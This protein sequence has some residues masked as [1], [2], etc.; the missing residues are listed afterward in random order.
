[1]PD[2]ECEGELGLG[3]K[4]CPAELPHSIAAFRWLLSLCKEVGSLENKIDDSKDS[5]RPLSHHASSQQESAHTVLLF[6]QAACVDF[7]LDRIKHCPGGE[8]T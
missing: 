8:A 5:C 7:R 2:V 1:M 3:G 6:R 4:T